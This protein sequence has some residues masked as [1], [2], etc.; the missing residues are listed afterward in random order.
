MPG[1][2]ELVEKLG[3]G[4]MGE[5][6][7]A[8]D[9]RLDRYVALKFLPAAYSADAGR[10]QRLLQEARAASALNHPNII[11]IYDIGVEARGDYIAME[12]VRGRT[13]DEI[14][15][16]PVEEAVRIATQ[17]AAALGAAHAAGIHHRDLKPANVMVAES[18]LVKVL[19]FGLAKIAEAPASGGSGPAGGAT[20]TM[21]LTPRTQ[22]GMILGTL[23]Y[24]SPEQAE[25]KPL[26]QRSDIFS[27]GLVLYEMLTGRG[28]FDAGSEFATLAAILHQP[29]HPLPAAV[30]AH[31]RAVVARCLEKDPARRFA[32]ME[33]IQ[34]AL[35]GPAQSGNT[36][37]LAV[38]PFAN[39][40]AGTDDEYFSDGLADEIINALAQIP[41]LRVTA[42]TSSFAFRGREQDIR[43]IAAR[44]NVAAVLEG[45]VRRAGNRVRVTAQLIDAADGYHLWSQRFDREMTS[46]FE[47]QDD[48]AGAIASAMKVQ[49]AAPKRATLNLDAY[50][51]YLRGRHHLLRY[52]AS[53]MAKAK[54]HFERAIAHDPAYALAY[55][56][57]ADFYIGCGSFDVIP[58][59]TAFS[60]A[61]ALVHKA[62][63]CDP[64][65]VEARGA[66][67]MLFA[68]ADYD[69]ASAEREFLAALEIDPG[70]SFV[71][72]R[73]ALW[74]LRTLG[75]FDE[76]EREMR[77]ALE[78]DPLSPLYHW[79]LG[80]VYY[81]AGKIDEAEARLEA[82]LE[83]DPNN[84]LLLWI[85]AA[86]KLVMG[87]AEAAVTLAQRGA[88]VF[89]SASGLAGILALAYA[90]TGRT[91]EIGPL[92]DGRIPNYAAALARY[93]LGDWDQAFAAL[94]RSFDA[95][96]SGALTVFYDPLLEELRRDS[97]FEGIRRLA[98]LAV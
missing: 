14:G 65:L 38:L 23:A 51:E 9:L 98:N 47:L 78:Q 76:A 77:R 55:A 16:L 3:E 26:D 90:R 40:S 11:T 57:L 36:A 52:T 71:R 92:L 53:G 48:I 54:E 19:D 67:A 81:C 15:A 43:E 64:S 83:L 88:A 45:S 50:H 91:A 80:I 25:G 96:E 28:A 94:E 6:Y 27:F 1:H 10:R 86:S 17:V 74:L 75:R 22:P 69:W 21:A 37:S 33:E 31:I 24:M 18:G 2:Y 4:G 5:V 46:L 35:T 84:L 95:R 60:Q 56:G 42:R 7:K 62:L 20:R 34:S 89:G 82:G 58:P 59:R 32:S 66:M 87:D 29:P 85:A 49:L 68:I 8:R 13:L 61:R 41:Q 93:A 30:P 72:Y 70:S 12:Y 73:Y 79:A 63:A 44:L 97:R 39:L